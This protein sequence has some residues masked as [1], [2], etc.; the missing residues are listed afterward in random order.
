MSLKLDNRTTSGRCSLSIKI[1]LDH[2]EE[3]AIHTEIREL[4]QI[5]RE[6]IVNTEEALQRGMRSMRELRWES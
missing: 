4:K 3:P 2:L 6:A 5:L 1:N